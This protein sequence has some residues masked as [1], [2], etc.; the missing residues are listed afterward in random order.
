M[1]Q[2]TQ[3]KQT[4]ANIL[5]LAETGILLALSIVLFEFIPVF[6]LPYGGGVTL[7]AQLPIVILGYRHGIKWG[8]FAG[9]A[10]SLIELMFGLG[11][12]AWV[13]GIVAYIILTF[14]DYIIAFTVLGLGGMFKKVIKNQALSIAAGAAVV[15]TI[16]FCC[17]IVSGATIWGSYMPEDMYANVWS[18]SFFYNASYMIPE[19]IL[20]TVVAFII[21]SIFE[22]RGKNVTMLKRK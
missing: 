7:C 15:S 22:L 21:G 3:T 19:L 18:Y 17:H 20:T 6:E 5:K 9:F 2:A 12:F 4:Q 13:T 11:N 8:F 1:A 16:R 10:L 14:A